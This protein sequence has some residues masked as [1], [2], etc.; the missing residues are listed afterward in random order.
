MSSFLIDSSALLQE[1]EKAKKS[2]SVEPDE[3]NSKIDLYKV[4]IDDNSLK[5]K[6]SSINKLRDL[7]KECRDQIKSLEG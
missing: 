6:N 4:F 7:K 2:K 3:K 5:T 1:E